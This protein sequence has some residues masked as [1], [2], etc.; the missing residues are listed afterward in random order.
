MNNNEANKSI[1]INPAVDLEVKKSVND[2]NPDFKNQVK[3]TLTVKNNGPDDAHKVKLTDKLPKSLIWVSDDSLGKY[4][5]ITGIWDIGSL[6]NGKSVKLSIV[7]QVD[8]T[9]NITNNVSVTSK[10]FDYNP[11]NN[12][13]NETIAV[14]VSGDLVILK[15]ANVSEVNYGELVKWTLNKY[16]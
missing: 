10:E 8:Q 3:W 6:K 13:D 12:F 7:S 16:I 4:D 2:T 9:G 11:A 15:T 5:P 14:N 1:F